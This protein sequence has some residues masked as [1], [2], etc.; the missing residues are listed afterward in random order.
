MR[1]AKSDWS[2][3]SLSDH[4]RPL[5]KRGRKAAPSMARH[6]SG[7]GLEM[8]VVLASSAVRV[9]ETLRLLQE[10]WLADA[11]ILHE[12]SLYLAS[13]EEIARVIH[14]L[15]DSWNSALVIGHNPG[16]AELVGRLADEWLDMPTAAVASFSSDT[17]SWTNALIQKSWNLDGYWKPRELE[18]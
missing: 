6:L 7:L 16:M 1:H 18:A 10:T 11:E 14:G 12:P 4:D 3:S 15:H 8:D 13:A 9:Q 2:N 5:N 17:E